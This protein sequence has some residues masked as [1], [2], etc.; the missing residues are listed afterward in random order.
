MSYIQNHRQNASQEFSKIFNEAANFALENGV[1]ILASRVTGKQ[2][3]RTNH[4]SDGP[5]EYYRVTTYIPFLD[6]FLQSLEERFSAENQHGRDFYMLLPS[7]IKSIQKDK[8]NDAILRIE[9][10]YGADYIGML[11]VEADIWFHFWNNSKENI[12]DLDFP[13]LLNFH[14]TLFPSIKKAIMIAVSLPATTCT[15]ERS[16]ST[17]RRVKTWLRSSMSDQRL[18]SLCMMSVH[19]ARIEEDNEFYEKIIN[20]FSVDKRRMQFNIK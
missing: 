10:F 6:S 2:K 19:R 17:M 1:E 5:Q 9:N 7:T 18:S 20:D 3:N 14:C 8:Y 16:F 12:T 11:S 15:V 13:A 4:P